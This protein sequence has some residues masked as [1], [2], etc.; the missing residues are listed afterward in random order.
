MLYLEGVN[1][2]TFSSLFYTI[3]AAPPPPP[4]R[5]TSYQSEHEGCWRSLT[6]LALCLSCSVV[7]A[8][9]TQKYQETEA[10]EAGPSLGGIRV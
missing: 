4:Q 5:R 3:I 8:E 10:R 9:D 2:F 6:T 1:M 7:S